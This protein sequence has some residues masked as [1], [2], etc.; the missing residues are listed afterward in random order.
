MQKI[1]K[2]KI[3]RSEAKLLIKHIRFTPNIIGYSLKEWLNAEHIIVAEDENEQLLGACLN[4]DISEKWTKIAALYVF[5]EFRNQ[6]IG[7]ALFYESFN[8]AMKRQKNVYT[9]SSNPIVIK[10][11]T[12]LE[13]TTFKNLLDFP[14]D[15]QAH[16]SM[17]YAHTFQWL[18][19]PYRIQEIIRKKIVYKLN[20]PFFYGLKSLGL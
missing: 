3:K 10:S 17:I 12:Q 6:G 11:M 13:F 20:D 19:N 4:Y 1:I 16:Q 15:Y 5:E 14:K 9:I 7:K 18:L 2:R 8:D